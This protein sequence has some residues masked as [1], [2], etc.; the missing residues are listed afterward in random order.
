MTGIEIAKRL[1]K[2]STTVS[3]WMAKGVFKT[4]HKILV[5]HR[6]IWEVDDKEAED[7][8]KNYVDGRKWPN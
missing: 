4:S 3:M 8:I 1:K 6:N 2:P 5:D 7:F